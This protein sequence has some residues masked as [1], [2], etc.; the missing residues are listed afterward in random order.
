VDRDRGQG[1]YIRL[2]LKTVNNNAQKMINSA[3]A[4]LITIGRNFKNLLEDMQKK[5]SELVMNWKELES[6]SEEPL[7]RRIAN[8]YKRMYYFVQL[9]Q[10]FTAPVEE[11][12]PQ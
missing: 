12:Q 7:P 1:K 11:E 3:S 9:L 10:F 6:A 2:I 4:N 5:P 8:N